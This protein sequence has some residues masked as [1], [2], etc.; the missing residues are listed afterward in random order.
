VSEESGSEVGLGLSDQ[1]EDPVGVFGGHEFLAQGGVAEQPADTGEHL[2][3][4]GDAGGDEQ[5]EEPD[6]VMIGGAEGTAEGMPADDDG[7]M[8]DQSGEG[9]ACVGQGDSVAD[10][11]AVQVFTFLEGAEQGLATFG[12]VGKFGQGVDQ[13]SEDFVAIL[14]GEVQLDG[15]G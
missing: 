2:E 5:E 7:G 4:L 8:F 6:G 1:L 3:M 13:L 14:S 9:G 11:G 10:A 15:G 12:T